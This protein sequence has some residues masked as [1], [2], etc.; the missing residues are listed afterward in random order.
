MIKRARQSLKSWMFVYAG[1]VAAI[2]V[3]GQPTD[4]RSSTADLLPSPAIEATAPLM[5]N[6][7]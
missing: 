6:D 4:V 5:R 7:I 3:S 2:A 1:M